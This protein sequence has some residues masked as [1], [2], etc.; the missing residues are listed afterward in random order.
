[1]VNVLINGDNLLYRLLTDLIR[2]GG[3]NG[4]WL[5]DHIVADC[6]VWWDPNVYAECPVLLP[7]AVRDPSCRGNKAKG[8]PD[9]WGAPNKDGYFLDDNSLVKGL[10]K[11]LGVR[12]PT[13]SYMAGKRLGQGWVAAHIWRDNEG[14]VL[15]SRDPL[16]YTFTPNL[17]W[18]PRQ[19]A[20]LSDVEG[21]PIQ[22]ALKSISY[23]LYRPTN[24]SGSRHEIAERAWS[25]L[26]NQLS[27]GS[28]IDLRRLSFFAEPE[29]TIAM[30][31]RRTKQVIDALTSIDAGSELNQKVVSSRY[32]EGLSNVSKPSRKKLLWELERHI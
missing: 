8:L 29:K 2:Q 16:L 11:A 9:E 5:V 1:M 12:G 30:R 24:L 19:I 13:G 3:S 26:P 14:D 25:Y 20:K 32:T 22:S 31:K 15:A 17:V 18:L 21:G 27:A 23:A 6:S 28:Q 7:W 10:V 4:Q